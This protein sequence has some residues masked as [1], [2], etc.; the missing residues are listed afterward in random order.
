MDK[1]RGLSY[2]SK[3]TSELRLRIGD[4][5]DEVIEVASEDYDRARK[6]PVE[7]PTT[8]DE[9]GGRR[10]EDKD[11]MRQTPSSKPGC[12]QRKATE[13]GTGPRQQLM[14]MATI[15]GK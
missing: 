1:T 14:H 4:L 3:D 5:L 9:I 13:S 15:T 11:A 12:Q 10:L 6:G 2:C 7:K 8:A